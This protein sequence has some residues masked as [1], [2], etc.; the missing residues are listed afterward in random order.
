MSLFYRDLKS[1]IDEKVN[2]MQLSNVQVG[3]YNADGSITSDIGVEP[4]P[5]E[6]IIIPEHI[7]KGVVDGKGY[8]YVNPL[9]D[10]D[11]VIY[12]INQG[13]QKLIVLGRV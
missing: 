9:T 8:V 10:G 7:R 1:I 3:K 6:A 2:T 4:Y 12:L 11:N 13:G 5:P